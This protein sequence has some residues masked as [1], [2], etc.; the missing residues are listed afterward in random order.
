MAQ[1]V[2]ADGPNAGVAVA[3]GDHLLLATRLDAGQL[4]LLAQDLG[5]LVEGDVDLEGLVA[6]ALAGLALALARL[7]SPGPQAVAGL[8]VALADAALVLVA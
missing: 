3:L 8:A 4:E 6:F 5:Q 2:G 1:A 7:P